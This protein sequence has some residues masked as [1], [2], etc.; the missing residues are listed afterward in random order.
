MQIILIL[1]SR[2]RFIFGE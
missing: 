1:R 2:S